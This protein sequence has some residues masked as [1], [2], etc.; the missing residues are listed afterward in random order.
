[1]ELNSDTRAPQGKPGFT[2]GGR[3]VL[4]FDLTERT[5]PGFQS[6]YLAGL[7]GPSL[8]FP[9]PIGGSLRLK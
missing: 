5:M 8:F 3:G 2:K 7:N 9:H 4:T 1:M 6:P